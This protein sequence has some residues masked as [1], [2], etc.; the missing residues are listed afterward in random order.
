MSETPN[1]GST[2]ANIQ[3]RIADWLAGLF[4]G[5]LDRITA[6]G[7][8]AQIAA[9]ITIALALSALG[10]WHY[11]WLD[12]PAPKKET[13][14]AALATASDIAGLNARISTL[15]VDIIT[16]KNSIDALAQIT[17]NSRNKEIPPSKSTKHKKR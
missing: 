13:P 16:L 6:W 17:G 10:A 2:P 5:A 1:T 9:A 7:R 12:R 15:S 3:Y 4:T 11:G 8:K 14:A